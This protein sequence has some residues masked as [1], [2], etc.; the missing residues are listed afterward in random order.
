ML[1]G[2]EAKWALCIYSQVFEEEGMAGV[3]IRLS[4]PL[5]KTRGRVA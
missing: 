4:V 1:R 3:L 5:G 2:L